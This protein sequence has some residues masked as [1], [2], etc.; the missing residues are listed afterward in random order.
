MHTHDK[1][2]AVIKAVKE[3]KINKTRYENYLKLLALKKNE[4]KY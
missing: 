4:K 2:C 3:G 1:D